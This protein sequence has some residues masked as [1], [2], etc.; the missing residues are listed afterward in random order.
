[1]AEAVE[2]TQLAFHLADKYRN[3]IIVYGDHLIAHTQMSVDVIA[4]AGAGA[5]QAVGARRQL[6]AAPAGRR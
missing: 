6:A 4:P 3:P 1:M 2:H 5:R